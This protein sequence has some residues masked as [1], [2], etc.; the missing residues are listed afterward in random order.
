MSDQVNYGYGQTVTAASGT[1]GNTI[2]YLVLVDR[3]T[4]Y[5]R[6][7]DLIVVRAI[8][9]SRVSCSFLGKQLISLHTF[10]GRLCK[11]MGWRILGQMSF[12]VRQYFRNTLFLGDRIRLVS[13]IG[14]AFYTWLLLF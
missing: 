3:E 2:K 5:W 8:A 1:T 14:C 13:T 10:L 4:I 12:V 7:S 6:H 9:I 11:E